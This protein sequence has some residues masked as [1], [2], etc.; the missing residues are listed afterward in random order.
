[1]E[2]I[3]EDRTPKPTA[4]GN[5]LAMA[6]N[7]EESGKIVEFIGDKSKSLVIVVYMR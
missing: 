4:W 3:D 6:R 1:L 7:I 2:R 5:N